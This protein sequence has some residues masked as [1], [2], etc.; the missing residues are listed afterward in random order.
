MKTGNKN[1][2]ATWGENKISSAVVS[3]YPNPSNVSFDVNLKVFTG[4]DVE[5][6]MYNQVGLEQFVHR[7]KNVNDSTIDRINVSQYTNGQYFIRLTTKDG[8]DVVKPVIV[9]K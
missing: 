3:I 8:I 2:F 7:F 4:K 6:R 1:A 5:V 9:L